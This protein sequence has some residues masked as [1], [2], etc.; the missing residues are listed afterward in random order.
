MRR[1][2]EREWEGGRKV[3][4]FLIKIFRDFHLPGVRT[5]IKFGKFRLRFSFL[6]EFFTIARAMT[7]CFR[8]I[9]NDDNIIFLNIF[10]FFNVRTESSF[11]I[12]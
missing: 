7:K 3:S 12:N 8:N 6:F 5:E 2:D 10:H 9:N 11:Q 4:N 1:E